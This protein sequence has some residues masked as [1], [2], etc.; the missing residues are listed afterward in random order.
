LHTFPR[1]YRD[2]ETPEPFWERAPVTICIAAICNTFKNEPRIV[3]CHDWQT[4][5]QEG[6]GSKNKERSLGKGGYCLT[7][8][9]DGQITAAY[10]HLKQAFA[11]WK[12]DIDE[13]NLTKIVRNGLQARKL[14]KCEELLRGRM[15]ISYDKFLQDGRA[16]LPTSIFE[17]LN[18][19]ILGMKLGA[20]FIVAAFS[21]AGYPMICETDDFAQVT[22]RD[23]FCVI[24][25]GKTLAR[26]ALLQRRF[27][28]V[29]DWPEAVYKVFEAKRIAENVAS[30]GTYTSLEILRKDGFRRS[31]KDNG[32]KRL[33][34]AFGKYGPK[35]FHG[36]G[37]ELDDSHFWGEP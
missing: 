25:E 35:L 14:E 30:V 27:T 24:G 19:E 26:A 22:P 6:I 9:F 1:L 21:P 11:E 29:N 20:Q 18:S 5:S 23:E 15:A 3:L 8:G 2:E 34:A 12:E 16:C 33:E 28:T 36:N 37:A 10:Q 31:L 32:L 17:A 7:S 4:S 13:T